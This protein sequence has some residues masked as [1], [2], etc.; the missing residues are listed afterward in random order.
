MLWLSR[1]GLPWAR[2]WTCKGSGTH[3]K[4]GDALVVEARSTM[5]ETMDMRGKWYSHQARRCSGRRGPPRAGRRAL[6]WG[7]R[8]RRPRRPLRRRYRPWARTAP[9]TL[10]EGKE[11]IT[12]REGEDV[13]TQYRGSNS[14]GMGISYNFDCRELVIIIHLNWTLRS[15]KILQLLSQSKKT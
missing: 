5:G 3:L 4:L 15:V 14:A 2:Q 9:A 7:S 1:Q 8:Q 12:L 6:E 10:R 13:T 11:V